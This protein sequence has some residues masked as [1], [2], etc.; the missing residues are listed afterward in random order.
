M[1]LQTEAKEDRKELKKMLIETKLALKK[2]KK[3]PQGQ[4]RDGL[5][6]YYTTAIRG[7][8]FQLALIN[9]GMISVLSMFVNDGK[10]E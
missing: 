2:A 9:P 7:L 5:V 4:Q 3:L 6:R 10:E 8:Q 1:S